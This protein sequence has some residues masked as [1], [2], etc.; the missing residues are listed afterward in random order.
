[1]KCTV[2][3]AGYR[4]SLYDSLEGVADKALELI[5]HQLTSLN[6]QNLLRGKSRTVDEQFTLISA[7]HSLEDCITNSIYIQECVPEDLELKRNVWKSVVDS[8]LCFYDITV[9]RYHSHV[10]CCQLIVCWAHMLTMMSDCQCA[11][12]RGY[13]LNTQYTITPSNALS[14][15]ATFKFSS[16]QHFTARINPCVIVPNTLFF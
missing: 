3:A 2:L 10:G 15:W 6:E 12:L 13:I 1:M 8:V 14:F 5:Y 9:H 16:V 4:V 11:P 7:A